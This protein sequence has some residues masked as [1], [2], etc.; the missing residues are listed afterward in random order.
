LGIHVFGDAFKTPR[1]FSRLFSRAPLFATLKS[2]PAVMSERKPDNGVSRWG[3]RDE[4]LQ[5]RTISHRV[6]SEIEC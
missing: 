5:L 6:P 4:Q 3:E 1:N 2:P